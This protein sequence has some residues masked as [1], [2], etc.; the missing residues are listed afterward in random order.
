MCICIY[1]QRYVYMYRCID[2]YMSVCKAT[3]HGS[4][5]MDATLRFSCDWVSSSPQSG[6]KTYV[7]HSHLFVLA[8]ASPALEDPQVSK[9]L[10]VDLIWGSSE[11]KLK[12]ASRVS[13]RKLFF[14][15]SFGPSARVSSRS[16]R[17]AMRKLRVSMPW[18]SWISRPHQ[19]IYIYTYTCVYMCVYVCR[20]VYVYTYIYMFVYYSGPMYVRTHM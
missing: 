5:Y 16:Q 10:V 1:V 14:V 7:A 6:S 20:Y 19:Y 15:A 18:V 9:T 8:F 2:V 12:N 17:I 3:A 11:Q 4:Q 13:P